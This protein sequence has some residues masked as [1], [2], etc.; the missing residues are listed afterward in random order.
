L[1]KGLNRQE[2]KNQN[3]QALLNKVQNY[4]VK[5]VLEK[6][7]YNRLK[8][9][10]ELEERWDEIESVGETP[11]Q[12]RQTL[13]PGTQAIDKFD[14]LRDVGRTLLI[15]GEPGS[16]KSITLLEIA[17]E[18]IERVEQDPTLPIPVVFNLSSWNQRKWT[19]NDWLV[20]EFEKGIYKIPKEISKAWIQNQ[21]LLLLLD[22]LDEV[23]SDLREPCVQALNQ[24]SQDYGL[25]EIIVCSR[26]QIYEAVSQPL[27]FQAALFLHPLTS[28]QIQHY[29]DQAGEEFSGVN[30]ALNTD[31]VLQ[32][33][34]RSPLMLS[35]MV[36]AY[37]GMPASA[38]TQMSLAERHEHLW[39]KY[40][41]RMF[42]RKKVHPQCPK[43]LSLYWLQFLSKKMIQES[44]PLFLIEQLQ[45]SWLSSRTQYRLYVFLSGLIAGLLTEWGF[46]LPL[47]IISGMLTF[48]MILG[49]LSGV[50][51]G[52]F[53]SLSSEIRLFTTVNWAWSWKN[54]FKSSLPGVISGPF[55]GILFWFISKLSNLA[56]L[57]FLYALN[58]GLMTGLIIAG[59]SAIFSGLFIS[60]TKTTVDTVPNDFSDANN[61][62]WQSAH[63]AKRFTMVALLT[64]ILPLSIIV[65]NFFVPLSILLGGVLLYAGGM[66]FIQHLALRLVLFQGRQ[67]PWD[68]THF[69]NHSTERMLLHKVGGGYQFI[70]DL[71]RRKIAAIP[72]STQTI[73][74]K[75]T[76][77]TIRWLT[78]IIVLVLLLASLF[79]PLAFN[80]WKILPSAAEIFIPRLNQGDL[81]LTDRYRLSH[82]LL[83]LKRW[84]IV[85][86]DITD[87]MRQ[88][89]FKYARDVKQVLGLPGEQIEII[90]DTVYVNDEPLKNFTLH[91]D[92]K[93][94]EPLKTS[95]KIPNKMYLLVVNNPKYIDE[96]DKFKVSLVSEDYIDSRVVFRYWPFNQIGKIPF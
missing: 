14:E 41:D 73:K 70:H 30:L 81:V 1:D 79:M 90:N 67:I 94:Y 95:L 2:Y 83:K 11:E 54:I 16:G 72:T 93:K 15:L 47:G 48:Q 76:K 10:L 65:N 32:E 17:K 18:L 55:L 4:W 86:F 6:S 50:S 66:G 12:I 77:N 57:S 64:I 3:R 68:Y 25:T 20:R 9:E 71:L 38:F 33:L 89:G 5:G 24:F 46:G 45:P 63:W 82:S 69:L 42:E 61:A 60:Q 37:Q 39:D 13:P 52:I 84:D 80:T 75:K 19:I 49:L 74:F 26:V 96:M 7:L 85:Y 92:A 44:Q 29:L 27:R 23:R 51:L 22:G 56:N 35:V 62:V 78:S 8:I 21:Q 58:M 43:N 87:E 31:P 28:S 59:I 36:L 34:A 91:P 40:I 53:A 88:S